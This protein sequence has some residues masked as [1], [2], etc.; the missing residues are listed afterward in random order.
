VLEQYISARTDLHL[1][2][3]F[4]NPVEARTWLQTHSADILFLDIRMPQES[5]MEMLQQLE[6]KPAI[7]FTTAY[8]DYAADAFDLA[9][10]DY[11][12]KPFSFERFCIAVDKALDFLLVNPGRQPGAG[13]QHTLVIKDGTGIVKIRFAEIQY[14]EAYQEYVKIFTDSGRYITYERMKNIEAILPSTHFM[15]VHRSYIVA[16]D[17]VKALHKQV[18][19]VEGASIPVSREMKEKLMKAIGGTR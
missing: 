19:D 12:R 13:E 16:L 10:V 17:R 2:A 9:A 11:L 14:V 1:A 5:G 15:R 8:A 3:V 6:K 7:I 4:R 18:A